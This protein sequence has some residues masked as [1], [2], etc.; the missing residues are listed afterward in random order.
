MLGFVKGISQQVNKI[1]STDRNRLPAVR[2][3]NSV[4]LEAQDEIVQFIG[5][6]LYMDSRNATLG[7]LCGARVCKCGFE[8]T[9]SG[10]VYPALIRNQAMGFLQ[11]TNSGC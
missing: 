7:E 2:T 4:S 5:G 11:A 9:I 8:G 6:L 10:R 3:E 1:S